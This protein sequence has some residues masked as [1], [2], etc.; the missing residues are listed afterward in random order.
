MYKS[1]RVASQVYG[2]AICLVAV[3]AL[4]ISTTS[5]VNA[6][7]DLGDP[8]HAGFTPQGS[9]SLASYENYKLDVL[10][11]LPQG[12]AKENYLANEQELKQ[13]YEAARQDKIS[14]VEHDSNKSMFISSLIIGMSLI[15]FFTHWRWVN[16]L[17]RSSA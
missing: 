15:L 12:E 10:R 3:I 16:K 6:V 4:L 7:L 1:N 13:M 14:K 8:L 9:P 2:Y 17:A 5:L 11:S